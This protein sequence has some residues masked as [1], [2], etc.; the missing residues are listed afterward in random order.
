[1]KYRVGGGLCETGTIKYDCD[2]TYKVYDMSGNEVPGAVP[3]E[4]CDC[5]T[6]VVVTSGASTTPTTVDCFG[7]PAS[8]V[9]D[10]CVVKELNTTKSTLEAAINNSSLSII[11][12]INAKADIEHVV[13]CDKITGNK[14][15]VMT[16]ISVSPPTT[17]LWDLDSGTTYTGTT[18]D[19]T[20]C[21][22]PIE[23]ETVRLDGC[24]GGIPI[25]GIAYIDTKSKVVVEELWRDTSGTW[26]HLP[27]TAT[28][29]E[30]NSGTSYSIVPMVD[31]VSGGITTEQYIADITM[32][33]FLLSGV[34][35]YHPSGHGIVLGSTGTGQTATITIPMSGMT[36][37]T[38]VTVESGQYTSPIPDP[39]V[40]PTAA[41]C[42][43]TIADP[44]VY[45]IAETGENIS[46]P[47]STAPMTF[48]ASAPEL[49]LLVTIPENTPQ[50]GIYQII[51]WTTIKE[52]TGC[53]YFLR[54]FEN[55][56]FV[57]DTELDGTTPYVIRGAVSL[58]CPDADGTP[59]CYVTT[60]TGA[61]IVQPGFRAISVYFDSAGSGGTIDGVQYPAGYTWSIGNDNAFTSTHLID[62]THSYNITEVRWGK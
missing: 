55:N 47:K 46:Q 23:V 13:M 9:T 4:P 58:S 27:A 61:Y 48:T 38:T 30:C 32:Q 41:P 57:A 14:V 56:A 52:D 45:T 62:S 36:V 7:E 29:G 40:Y 25:Y 39:C 18:N 60:I 44:C 37:G 50:L 26:G 5:P 21:S 28:V 8:R 10:L 53:F 12:A 59:Y 33:S 20:V 31:Y 22:T 49:T 35:Q 1:M 3:T 16:D 54:K 34:A 6:E 2:G 42:V 51:A 17:T 15:A 43:Y 19:L 11:A 24:D